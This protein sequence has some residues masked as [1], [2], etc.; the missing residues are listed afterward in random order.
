MSFKDAQKSGSTASSQPTPTAS[1][2]TNNHILI[3]T[4]SQLQVGHVGGSHIYGDSYMKIEQQN[5]K[6]T[7]SQLQQ[8]VIIDEELNDLF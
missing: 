8:E 4:G 6:E 1:H 7:S 3:S 2:R 5:T